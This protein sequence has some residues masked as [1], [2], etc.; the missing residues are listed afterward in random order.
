MQMVINGCQKIQKKIQKIKNPKKKKIGCKK[1]MKYFILIG[2]F[3][4]II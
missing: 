1:F 2:T 4:F 3:Y